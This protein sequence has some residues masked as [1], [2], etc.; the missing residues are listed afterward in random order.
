MRK[1]MR[2]LLLLTIVCGTLLSGC[3]SSK[4]S[5]TADKEF[6]Q[7][8]IGCLEQA[9]DL[10]KLKK[11]TEDEY[12][13]IVRAKDSS[14]ELLVYRSSDGGRSFRK[15]DLEWMKDMEFCQDS[16]ALTSVD[17]TV[18]NGY[19]VTYDILNDSYER[20]E[21]KVQY[22][23][24][25]SVTDIADYR[26]SS[27]LITSKLVG[28]HIVVMEQDHITLFDRNGTKQTEIK[29]D[30]A[31]D[32]CEDGDNLLLVCEDGL[33]EYDL[34]GK[35]IKQY[36]E[37]MDVLTD[38]LREVQ[39]KINTEQLQKD[40]VC[41]DT[42]GV[43]Y[44]LLKDGIYR[45]YPENGVVEQL[46]SDD[47]NLF[48][49]GEVE[50]F[51]VTEKKEI[52]IAG[53]ENTDGD[54]V[55][56]GFFYQKKIPYF[57]MK[58]DGTI[59][60]SDTTDAEQKKDGSLKVYSLENS[61]YIDQAIKRLAQQFP[62]MNIVYEVGM[63]KENGLTTQDAVNAFHTQMLSG[64]GPD[65]IFM[66]GL[67]PDTYVQNGELLDLNEIVEQ[68]GEDC[69]NTV[70]NAFEQKSA[71]YALPTR[72]A[73]PMIFAPKEQVEQ[74]K[75]PK[76]LCT[77]LK[78]SGSGINNLFVY[79]GQA[80]YDT[81]FPLYAKD[82]L[83]GWKIEKEAMQQFVQ[84]AKDI[85][86][87]CNAHNNEVDVTVQKEAPR[88]FDSFDGLNVIPGINNYTGRPIDV[89]PDLTVGQLRSQ[90]GVMHLYTA[91]DYMQSNGKNY[92]FDTMSDVYL[93]KMIVS[94]NKECKNK[95]MA[96]E[97]VQY[98]LSEDVINCENDNYIAQSFGDYEQV[99]ISVNK[100]VREADADKYRNVQST[101]ASNSDNGM[102]SKITLHSDVTENEAEALER[103]YSNAKTCVYLDRIAEDIVVTYL[104]EVVSGNCTVEE[105]AGKI[106]DELGMYMEE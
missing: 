82:I 2:K 103:C 19:L 78:T 30:G 35:C 76:E 8:D 96:K 12:A 42:D 7:M 25:E 101:I 11:Y 60:Y 73:I 5:A 61:D 46:I 83:A 23:T 81:L 100:K 44:L 6:Q 77:H 17:R 86:E 62:D 72:F 71:V 55:F 75:N 29:Q 94:I 50:G 28:D 9:G 40:M 36:S 38:K 31:I 20:V 74:L 48:A 27:N 85:Y 52:Y 64:D 89:W 84:D 16:C 13:C 104:D 56:A 33:M 57:T 69:L 105:A 34:Q 87:A 43:V 15:D 99:G 58:Q 41:C 53:R 4:D 98:L 21:T 63:D 1:I 39:E 45:Y 80:L 91:R 67:N 93:P 32:L 92:V 65:I 14:G 97:F 49:V 88:Q 51:L 90:V 22:I 66:D 79:D 68:S 59:A 10:L 24:K 37:K 95:E 18:D 106:C 54:I 102:G 3:G 47:R 26:N 70:V